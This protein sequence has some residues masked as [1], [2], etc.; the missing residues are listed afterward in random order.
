MEIGF[1]NTFLQLGYSFRAVGGRG[2]GDRSGVMVGFGG[3]E[4][5]DRSLLSFVSQQGAIA[6]IPTALDRLEASLKFESKA[7]IGK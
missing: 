1:V 7:S 3:S 6:L 5:G 2:A 4:N